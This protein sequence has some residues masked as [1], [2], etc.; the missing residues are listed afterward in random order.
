MMFGDHHQQCAHGCSAQLSTV[1]PVSSQANCL[2]L[3]VADVKLG[4]CLPQLSIHALTK[5]PLCLYNPAPSVDS[6][7]RFPPAELGN[8]HSWAAL[9]HTADRCAAKQ[10]GRL[11]QP[12]RAAAHAT[13]IL[14]LSC[15]TDPGRVTDE[16]ASTHTTAQLYASPARDHQGVGGHPWR[17]LASMQHKRLDQRNPQDGGHG[18]C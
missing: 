3:T 7:A 1:A 11:A 14:T 2:T 9:E 8:P 16:R 13:S 6:S 18:W 10:V 5:A 12:S 15:R 17:P 4:P